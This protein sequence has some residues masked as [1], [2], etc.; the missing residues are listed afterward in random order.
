MNDMVSFFGYQTLFAN[1]II[2]GFIGWQVWN[3]VMSRRLNRLLSQIRECYRE[4]VTLIDKLQG[5][6]IGFTQT[7]FMVFIRDMAELSVQLKRL[8]IPTMK[9]IELDKSSLEKCRVY[10]AVLIVTSHMQ[11][12]RF[13]RQLEPIT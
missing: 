8:G 3:A 6:A 1:L 11:N 13:A 5:E 9:K 7:D 10:L 2:W 12:I 4:V